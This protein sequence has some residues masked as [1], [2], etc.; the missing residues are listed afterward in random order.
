M[1]T[2]AA[3]VLVALGT[4]CGA[5]AQVEGDSA[6]K[7]R[8]EIVRTAPLTIRGT[9]FKAGERV[10]LL[11]TGDGVET[12]RIAATTAGS[13]TARFGLPAGRCTAL[14]VQ[15][16]GNMGSRATIDRPTLDCIEP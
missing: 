2:L 16:I 12:R 1:R 5:A 11:A 3:I 15:A 9:G 7:A 6:R 10:R 4:A 13:F 8:V 14:V